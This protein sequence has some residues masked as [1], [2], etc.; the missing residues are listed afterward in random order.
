MSRSF[1]QTL[2]AEP[3]ALTVHVRSPHQRGEQIHCGVQRKTREAPAGP[4]AG[5]SQ[6]CTVLV[7]ATAA[8]VRRVFL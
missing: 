3:R 7:A 1:L 2:E 5:L 4:H 6:D 8:D